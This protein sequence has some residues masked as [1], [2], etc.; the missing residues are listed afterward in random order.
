[1]EL[2]Y[3]L[4]LQEVARL[5]VVE[6]IMVLNVLGYVWCIAD[7]GV[8]ALVVRLFCMSVDKNSFVCS[9]GCQF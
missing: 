9:L 6:V 4:F 2:V 1:M 8:D 7:D 5:G 3:L